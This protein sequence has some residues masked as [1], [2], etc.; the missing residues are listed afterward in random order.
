VNSLQGLL[1]CKI[2]EL[3]CHVITTEYRTCDHCIHMYHL[4]CHSLVHVIYLG[5]S[6][7]SSH[8]IKAR[9]LHVLKLFILVSV[10]EMLPFVVVVSGISYM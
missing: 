6:S 3:D 5:V 4:F 1:N 7:Q 9:Q 8:T 2:C 10:I